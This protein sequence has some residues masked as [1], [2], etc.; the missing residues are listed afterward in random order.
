MLEST[1]IQITADG[2]ALPG[3]QLNMP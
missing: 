1:S 3:I 2:W